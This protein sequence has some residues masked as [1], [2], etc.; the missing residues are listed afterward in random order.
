M[1]YREFAPSKQL[2]KYVKCFWVLQQPFQHSGHKPELILPDGCPEI[3]FNLAEPFRRLYPDRVEIQP[4]SIVAGQIRQ[5][6]LVE[7]ARQVNV[8]AVRFQPNGIYPLVRQPLNELT[9]KIE[10]IDTVLGR[11]GKLLEQK[12]LDADTTKSRIIH[13]EKVLTKRIGSVSQ[14]PFVE[15]ASREIAKTK[16]FVKVDELVKNLG[17]NSKTL[18]RH[19]NRE[20]GITP[21]FYSRVVRFQRVLQRLNCANT[22]SWADLAYSFNYSDQAHFIKDF[23]EFAGATP[24]SFI[25]QNNQM[26]DSFV[27]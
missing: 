4:R 16:A 23:K 2:V 12:V 27:G 5:H 1:F 20:V 11:S 7:P 21:K 10:S 24:S 18:E 26:S 13:V 3:V 19:F 22:K 8:F 17:T 9:N 6:I 15:R 25:K 14:S